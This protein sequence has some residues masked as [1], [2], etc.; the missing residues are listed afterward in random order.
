MA[1][2]LSGGEDPEK[3]RE[4]L[5]S[6]RRLRYKLAECESAGVFDESLVDEIVILE[7]RLM[8]TAATSITVVLTKFE[9]ATIDLPAIHHPWVSII[10][11]DMMQLSGLDSS[12]LGTP[13][14]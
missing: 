2:N 5:N 4:D 1:K 9:I 12:P 3:F 14:L 7:D 8:A 13:L 11:T 10:R 6:Y